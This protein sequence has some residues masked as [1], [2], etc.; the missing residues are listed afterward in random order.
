VRPRVILILCEGLTEKIYFTLV[1]KNKRISGVKVSILEK[2]GQH[3]SLVKRCVEKRREYAKGLE[4]DEDD[5][6]VWAVCDKDSLKIGY[7]KLKCFADD[8]NVRLAF[9]DP[10]FETFLVQH[11][12][13]KKITEKGEYLECVLSDYIGEEYCK[14]D[15]N[16]LDKMIDEKP[17]TLTFAIQNSEKLNNHARP[18][19]L[20]VQK[21]TARLL[22]L[23]R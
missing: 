21:L 10:Q 17:A 7:L 6:E 16:W 11:F 3:K 19:F 14:S 9:S 2:Q 8:K 22:E 4:I 18:P 23:I 5:I 12:E 20:T 1:T 15:L 13:Y